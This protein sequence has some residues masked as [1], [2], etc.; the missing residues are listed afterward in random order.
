MITADIAIYPLKTSNATDV[1]NNSIKSLNNTNVQ[2]S[3]NSM[4]TKITGTK[5]EVFNS[6]EAVFSEAENIGGEVSMVATISNACD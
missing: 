6:I 3:V 4:N 1:I 5:S 2:Y